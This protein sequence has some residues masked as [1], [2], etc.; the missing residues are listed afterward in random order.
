MNKKKTT[1][2]VLSVLGVLSLVLITAGVTYAFFSYAKQGTTE[3][4]ITTGTITF[5]YDEK[6]AEGNG[7]VITDALPMADSDGK[8]LTGDN[9]VFDFK[10]T[11]ET[12]G[13]ANIPYQVTARMSKDSDTTLQDKVKL[14]LTTVTGDVETAAEKT[15]TGDKVNTYE[16]LAQ[17]SKVDSSVATE[18]LIYEGVVPANSKAPAKYEQNFK[19][20]MW[21]AGDTTDGDVNTDFSP[22]EFKNTDDG[23]LITSTEYYALTAEQQAKYT[24]IAYV[25]N[26][27]KTA[28]TQEEYDALDDKTG[29][30]ASEQLYLYNARKFAV[31]VNVYANATV[32]DAGE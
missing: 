28:L 19:L 10:V 8:V 30:E 23:T 16:S 17:Y 18:K 25:N 29:Y 15:V 7:I 21:L 26:S 14:Y 9:N 31:T 32:V 12:T 27:T 4:S 1:G 13:N 2:I 20:R 11:A 6:K 22:L 3:N 24:R 5:L